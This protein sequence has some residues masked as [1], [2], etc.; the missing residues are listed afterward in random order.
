MFWSRKRR[1]AYEFNVRVARPA[2]PAGSSVLRVNEENV[3]NF[4][5]KS[6]QPRNEDW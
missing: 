2:D 3:K 1:L 5:E 6:M 4:D